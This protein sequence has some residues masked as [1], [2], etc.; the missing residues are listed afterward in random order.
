MP[1]RPSADDIARKNFVGFKVTRSEMADLATLQRN[2][3][4]A[5]QSEAIR[6]A[7]RQALHQPSPAE[8]ASTERAAR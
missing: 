8:R 6:Q 1:R 3:G 5:S 2:L 4:A 7:I